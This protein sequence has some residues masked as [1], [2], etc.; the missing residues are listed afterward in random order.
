MSMDVL[1]FWI[2]EETRWELAAREVRLRVDRERRLEAAGV[3]LEIRTIRNFLM[4]R[5]FWRELIDVAVL[6]AARGLH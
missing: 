3:E 2:E 1:A 6:A 4:A 5:D